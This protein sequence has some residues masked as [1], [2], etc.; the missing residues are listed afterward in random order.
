MKTCRDC[1]TNHN[2]KNKLCNKC[3]KRASDTVNKRRFL[4]NNKG[5]CG[6]CGKNN[7]AS[8]AMR[9]LACSDKLNK[10]SKELADAHIK[11]NCC[12]R[13]GRKLS[14][15]GAWHTSDCAGCHLKYKFAF[16]GTKEE[17]EKIINDLLIKQNY[18]CAMTD[19]DLKTNKY[20]IDHII[21]KFADR[22]RISD[23]TN[24]QLIVENANMFKKG[25]T[26]EEI[27]SIAVDM[28]KMA[29]KEGKINIADIML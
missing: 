29:I 25:I 27:L 17:A 18:R 6:Q 26:V 13:C 4:L 10:R 23:P 7:K 1:G 28:V 14:F 16:T 9:C 2:D 22:S 21:A 5:L 11:N 8:N 24:W 3:S 20:H 19:R 12:V 15:V